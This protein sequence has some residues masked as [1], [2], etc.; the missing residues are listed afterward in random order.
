MQKV[1]FMVVCEE[2]GKKYKISFKRMMYPMVTVRHI[3]DHIRRA[4]Q[5]QQLFELYYHGELLIDPQFCSELGIG[6]GDTII[7]K[8]V[9]SAQTQ[10]STFQ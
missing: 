3:R 10:E 6:D 2:N 5:S 9:F 7:M 4:M 1:S 8:L